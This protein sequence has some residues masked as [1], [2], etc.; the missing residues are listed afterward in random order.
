VFDKIC[1]WEIFDGRWISPVV[2]HM[3][4]LLVTYAEAADKETL[5][6]PFSIKGA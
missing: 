5:A 6:N 1:G 3:C 4:S 2:D